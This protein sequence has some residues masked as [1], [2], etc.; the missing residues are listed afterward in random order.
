MA[1]SGSRLGGI[2]FR[3]LR[4]EDLPCLRRWLSEGPSLQWYASGSAPTEEAI[5]AKYLPRIRGDERVRS[6]LMT[7]GGVDAGFFQDHLLREVPGH[8]A[9]AI[10]PDFAG[11]DYFLAP[12]FIGQGLGP[13][14][15]SAFVQDV[16]RRERGV[17]GCCADPDPENQ[18]SVRALRK[19]GFRKMP[20]DDPA[21]HPGAILLCIPRPN[22]G[23]PPGA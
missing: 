22:E 17:L 5:L 11:I 18:R 14:A 10:A 4:T 16:F 3:P 23:E 12:E 21:R 8:P 13:R 9:A 2:S 1:E 7:S 15:I 20:G 6:W 19:A